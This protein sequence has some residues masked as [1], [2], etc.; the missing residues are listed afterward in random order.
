MKL[1][2]KN[3][4]A[5]NNKVK[6]GFINLKQKIFLKSISN[7]KNN[8]KNK[9]VKKKLPTA[10]PNPSR[11]KYIIGEPASINVMPK[12]LLFI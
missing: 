3:I 7:N 1:I 12:L 11:I 8:I 9:P 6:L 10:N 4:K 2:I 5:G